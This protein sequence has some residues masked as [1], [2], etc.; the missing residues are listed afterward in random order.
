ML[1]EL[2]V[3]NLGVIGE[4]SLVLGPGMTAVTGETGAGKTLVVGAIDLLTGG[5]AASGLVRP[6][7][8]CAE[9]EGR[10]S[11][12]PAYAGDAGAASAG[13][14]GAASAGVA[15]PAH[16]GRAG[17][18]RAASAGVADAVLAGVGGEGAAADDGEVVVRR[19]L[20]RHGRSRSYIDG[21]LATLRA[22]GELGRSL[23]DLHGQH[24]HQSLLRPAL[25]RAC[26]DRFGAVDTAALARLGDD[27]RQMDEARAALGGDE[28]ARAREI[29][30]LRYQLAEIDGAAVEGPGE[31]ERLEEAESLLADAAAHRDAARAAVALLDGDGPVADGL[32][33]ALA[34]LA[35]RSPFEELVDRL[36][37]AEAE[38]SDLAA[39]VRARAEDIDENPEALALLRE[40]R[41]T[42]AGLRRKYGS[43]LSEVF[44]FADAAA[45]RLAQ[46]ENRE[47]RASDLDRRRSAVAEAVAAEQSRVRRERAAAAPR[48][49]AAVQSHL[50]DLAM[51]AARVE[52]AVEGAAGERVEFLL[53]ANP[54]HEPRPLARVASGGELARAMLAL[55]LVLISGPPTLVFDEVDAGVGGA[56]AHAVGRS[57][58]ALAG[59]HQVVVVTHLA[60]VAAHADHHVLVEKSRGGAGGAPSTGLRVLGSRGREIELSRMLSGSPHSASARRH[61]RELLAAAAGPVG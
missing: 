3:R 58:A 26:L 38:V 34:A 47:E 52:V 57:L 60:Q 27:L 18:A 59:A 16:T 6:G 14:A 36:A 43:S 31:D 51:A 12:G 54:G 61:A 1:T 45:E 46:L 24:A 42:L 49:A 55:R 7:A 17:A 29:D 40:R 20:P 37:G 5:R 22:L 44:E 9:I 30:L 4:V 56:A 23:V 10:F 21:R 19:V 2:V 25:Q 32:G 28:R 8:A 35:G 33:R 41:Q 48:L 53:A 50:R 15:G 39:E 13:V 11:T